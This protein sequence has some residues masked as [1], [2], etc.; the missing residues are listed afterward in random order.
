MN[1]IK[2]LH[3]K[4]SDLREKLEICLHRLL[5]SM[6][7]YSPRLLEATGHSLFPGGKRIRP[8]ISMLLCED[9]GGAGETLLPAAAALELIH[10][11]SL[12]HDDLPALDN[13]DMRRGRPTCHR[14]FGEGTALLAGDGL[15]GLSFIAIQE[16]ELSALR[17]NALTASLALAYMLLCCG[18]QRDIESAP[19]S[20]SLLETHR[21]KT[22]ALFS[23][24]FEFGFI[25]SPLF[26]SG[27]VSDGMRIVSSIGRSFGVCFQILNDYLDVHGS[28]KETG[29]VVSSDVKNARPTYFMEENK[30]KHARETVHLALD[31]IERGFDSLVM[32]AGGK[33]SSDFP[34]TRGMMGDVLAKVKSF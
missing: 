27:A 1:Q 2:D 12:I 3:S 11:S 28:E 34:L 18:Q 13:D 19:D 20:E 14:V 15:L 16:A 10:C 4:H 5:Q 31:E 32:L 25:G 23:S 30:V 26:E 7:E 22:G 6:G 29:R 9:L 33:I 24:T 21:L 17:K 8:L